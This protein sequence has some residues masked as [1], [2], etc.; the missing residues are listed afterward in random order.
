MTFIIKYAIKYVDVFPCRKGFAVLFHY[1]GYMKHAFLAVLTLL[2]GACTI[3]SPDA[4]HEAVWVTKPIFFGHGG[5]EQ[6]P[7]TTGLEYGAVSSDVIDVDMLPQRV[8]ME[9]DDAMTKSGVPVSFHLVVTFKVK[10]SVDLVTKFG[11]DRDSTGKW[12]FWSRNIDQPI[13][14]T[15]RDAVKKREMQ[16][17]AIDM[18][19]A[20]AVAAEV[21][22][23]ANKVI[24][25]S[26]VPIEIMELSVGRINPPD[27]IKHQRIATAEQ[28]QRQI[29]EVQRKL[30]EDQRKMAEESRAAA[31]NAYNAKMQLTPQQYVQIKQIEML[32]SV[33]AGG[34]CTFILGSGGSGSGVSPVLDIGKR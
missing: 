6:K 24:A 9:F 15:V 5:I 34:K 4:G 7:V 13:R 14:T 3:A 8:D 27:A 31:D 28:E 20:D 21:R 11:A 17:M 29:T 30:A 25:S 19:A 2:L 1:E 23:A 12:G 26:Q 18:S 10:N 16:E 32:A 22:A 33:C